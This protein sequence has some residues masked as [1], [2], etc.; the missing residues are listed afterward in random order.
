MAEAGSEAN[1]TQVRAILSA[2]ID[3]LGARL[4]ELEN[5]TPHHRLALEDI[6]RWQE[7]AEGTTPASD[8]SELPPGSPIGQ[9]RR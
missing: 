2:K 5:P 7:R 8:A 1:V 6:K 9:G 3:E 4:A